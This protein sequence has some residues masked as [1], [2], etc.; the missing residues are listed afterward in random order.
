ME[1][2]AQFV[3][4]AWEPRQKQRLN[5]VKYV[6]MRSI[7]SVLANVSTFTHFFHIMSLHYSV[8]R[9][10]DESWKADYL[11][12]VSLALDRGRGRRCSWV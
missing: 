2:N 7:R 10:D 1:T 11:C 9:A 3:M 6:R 5:S 4:K 12:L 8:F